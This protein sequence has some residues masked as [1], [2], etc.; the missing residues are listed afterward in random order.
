MVKASP[1]L[2]WTF[3]A[4]A[5]A[6]AAAFPLAVRHAWR[7][8]GGDA[9][10]ARR[11]GML[12]A[13]GVA[14][15]MGMTGAAAG[16]GALSFVTRPPTM[17]PVILAIWVLALAVGLS[18]LGGRL[19]AGVPLA[20]LVGFQGFRMPLE[21]LMHRAA[22]IGL[23]P[24]QMSYSGLNFDIVTG[25]TALVLGVALAVR[26]VPPWVVHAWNGMGALLLLNV[27]A[28]AMLSAPGP[29][30][31][32]HGEPANVWITQ[33]PWVWLPTIHVAAALIGHIVIFRALAAERGDAGA[34]P[35]S[36]TTDAK[37]A[38]LAS[39]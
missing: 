30:R 21:L 26:R 23:M 33:F 14:V 28:I 15:W 10:P 2:V 39:R 34:G 27:V 5:L 32:F 22:E 8:T 13:A 16:A 36:S 9:A 29:L 7:R 37:R 4:L 31:V 25:A 24:P 12:A 20:V 35:A 38:V 17:P 1:A 19:A 11:A 3:T 18:R 6:V